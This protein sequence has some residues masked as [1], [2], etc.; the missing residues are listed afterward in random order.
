MTATA[1]KKSAV[2]IADQAV[3]RAQIEK[4]LESHGVTEFEFKPK[5]PLSKI[6]RKASRANQARPLHPIDDDWV[7]II[8]EGMTIDPFAFPPIV[9]EQLSGG[10]FKILDGNHREE[11]AGLLEMSTFPAYVITQKLTETQERMLAMTGNKNH[12]LSVDMETRVRHAVWLVEARNMKQTEA[13]R[14]MGAPEHRVQQ[15]VQLER[16]TRRAQAVDHRAVSRLSGSTRVR[17][18]AVRSDVVHEAVTKLAVEGSMSQTEVN[19][20]VSNINRAKNE[21]Q[22]LTVVENE[23]KRREKEIQAS[24]GG[25]VPMPP[26]YR[27]VRSTLTRATRIDINAIKDTHVDPEVRKQIKAQ[28]KDAVVRIQQLIE[29]L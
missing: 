7:V 6:D 13:A 19:S 18:D 27:I 9:V 14:V 2:E 17:L 16:A 26:V 5:L 21:Q 28:A 24:A 4:W 23:R 29:Q 11:A 12:G 20:L 3:G 22:Q 1:S 15:M 25:K 8:A 10:K